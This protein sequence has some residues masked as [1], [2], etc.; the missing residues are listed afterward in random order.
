MEETPKNARLFGGQQISQNLLNKIA[1]SGMPLHKLTLKE[2]D[3]V[4]LLRNM[5]GPRE[6]AN[7]TRLLICKLHS[8]VI[9]AEIVIGC[10]IGKVV[11]TPPSIQT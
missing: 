9:E 8:R 7:G 1:P 5:R 3:P 4:V 6:Q 10:S 11:F 2:G